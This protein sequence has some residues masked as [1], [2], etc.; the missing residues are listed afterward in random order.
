[1]SSKTG[2]ST[3]PKAS[4]TGSWCRRT[5]HPTATRRRQKAP[6]PQHEVLSG[7]RGPL[8]PAL[9]EDHQLQAPHPLQVR[10]RLQLQEVRARGGRGDPVREPLPPARLGEGLRPHPPGLHGEDGSGRVPGGVQEDGSQK[11]TSY[12]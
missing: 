1:M 3:S 5:C 4:R 2:F 9:R 10:A 8:L 6:N 12:L 11:W 7:G